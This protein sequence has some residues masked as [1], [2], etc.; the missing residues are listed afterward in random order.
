MIDRSLIWKY[1][2]KKY[3]FNYKFLRITIFTDTA[4]LNADHWESL[5]VKYLPHLREFE[6]HFR[7]FRHY[8]FFCISTIP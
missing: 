5:I 2:L 4:Y 3:V 1:L 6:F 8:N 7:D